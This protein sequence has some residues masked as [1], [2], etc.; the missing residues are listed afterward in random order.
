MT[1][2]GWTVGASVAALLCP[3]CSSPLEPVACPQTS[4]WGTAGCAQ[5]IVIVEEPALDAIEG[6]S[7]TVT[8]KS[9]NGGIIS[10]ASNPRFGRFRMLLDLGPFPLTSRI[11]LE[12][13]GVWLV[14]YVIA[15]FDD[16]PVVASD[17]V[18]T[19]VDFVGVGEVP[20]VETVRLRPQ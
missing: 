12:S 2:F 8:A 11:E 10:H 15:P 14:A 7:L 6:R 4:E 5:V 18:L 3:G 1:R 16:E 13:E 9:M 19:H 20:V 17:S